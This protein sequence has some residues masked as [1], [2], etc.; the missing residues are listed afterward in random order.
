MID[1]YPFSSEEWDAC[2]KVLTALKDDPFANPDN[3]QLKTLITAIHKK[4]RKEIRHLE[5]NVQELDNKA[6]EQEDKQK[7]TETVI[8]KKAKENTTIYTHQ[9]HEDE[10]SSMLNNPVRCYACQKDYKQLH[11]FY[12]RLCPECAELNYNFRQLEPDFK[13]FQVVITGGRVKIGYA[14]ALKF[15]KSGAKVLVSTRFPALAW[16]QFSK[17]PDFEKWQQ[18]L[19]LYGLDLRDIKAVYGFIEYCQKEIP[20]LD[21]LVNNA[22]QTIKYPLSYYQPLIQQEKQILLEFQSPKLL[23]NSTPIALSEDKLLEAAHLSE[24]KLNRFGQPVDYRNKNSWN[25]TLEEIGLEELLEVNLINHISPYILIS[26]LY[27]WMK[28][29][30]K[31]EKFIIN[32]TSSEGQFSYI[33]K[34]IHHPHTN[35]TKAALNMLTRTSAADYVKNKVYMNSVDVGWVSTGAFEEKRARLFDELN[36]PPLDSVDGAMRIIHPV[37]EI[38]NGNTALYGKLLKNY[39]EVSW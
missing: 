24:V 16:E 15:L 10:S 9:N 33:N 22:A 30:P 36:I 14:T 32:V 5:S 2:I 23:G 37:I 35:M 34:T 26:G 18:N 21:I 39:Q 6:K 3:Q 12:H 1:Q 19:T 20:Y 38:Q 8:I 31:N 27:E 11:F 13:D 17:E 25:A 28:K 7:I 29:C 4:A